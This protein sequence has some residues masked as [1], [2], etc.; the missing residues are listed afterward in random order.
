M[1]TQDPIAERK[2][3]K[4]QRRQGLETLAV[5]QGQKHEQ[6]RDDLASSRQFIVEELIPKSAEAG[7]PFDRLAKLLGISRQ[8]LYRWQRLSD[9]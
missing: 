5:E 4:L 6:L 3:E 7:I 8:T 9:R 1:P 2:A